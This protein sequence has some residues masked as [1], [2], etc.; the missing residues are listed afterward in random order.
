MDP[1]RLLKL[2][3]TY[4]PSDPAEQVMLADTIRLIHAHPT[5]CAS[6]SLLHGHLTA[7]AWILNSSRTHVLMTH[8]RKLNR[9]LQLGGHAD[10]DLDLAR[11]ALREAQEESGLKSVH[12]LASVPFDVDVHTIPARANVPEHRHYD[13][14]FLFAAD[15]AEPL[16]MSDESLDLAWLALEQL[17]KDHPDAS[18]QRLIAKTDEYPR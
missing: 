4:Q 13:V 14:R 5:D 3:T 15:D 10:G 17:K 16:V 1:S 7:S 11:V 8:H 6:R 9:W 2:L 12:C 18:I